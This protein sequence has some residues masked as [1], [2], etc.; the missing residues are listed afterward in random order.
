MTTDSLLYLLFLVSGDVKDS[1]AIQLALDGSWIGS[2]WKSIASGNTAGDRSKL[3]V[4]GCVSHV[5]LKEFSNVLHINLVWQEV[6]SLKSNL[7]MVFVVQ[8]LIIV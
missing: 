5:D 6:V 7:E 3:I 1:A 8:N 2:L 4:F